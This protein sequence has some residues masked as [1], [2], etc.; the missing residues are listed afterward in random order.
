MSNHMEDHIDLHY[1]SIWACDEILKFLRDTAPDSI[2][3]QDLFEDRKWI[4]ATDLARLWFFLRVA[5]DKREWF[6]RGKWATIQHME[7]ML[8]SEARDTLS[9]R[10]ARL[11]S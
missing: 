11:K 3:L 2:E 8:T 5:T 4:L 1:L 6:P 7:T 9:L 10:I